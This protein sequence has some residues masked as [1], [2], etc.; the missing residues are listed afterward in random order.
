MFFDVHAHIQDALFGTVDW[1]LYSQKYG[2]SKILCNGTGEDDWA[3]VIHLSDQFSSVHPML[4]VHPWLVHEQ[5]KDWADLLR[6]YLQHSNAGLGEIGLDK[7]VRNVDFELQKEFFVKQLDIAHELQL[8]VTIHCLKAFGHLINLLNSRQRPPKG[9]LLHSYS[10]PL[11]LIDEFI[12]LG[13]YFSFSAYFLNDRKINQR[14]LFKEI[15]I[16]RIL[17]ESDA[18]HMAGPQKWMQ[19]QSENHSFL[20]AQNLS[21]TEP[22]IVL[23]VYESLAQIHSV[24]LEQLKKNISTNFHQL[25]G[26]NVKMDF[27]NKNRI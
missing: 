2:L 21:Q 4:G 19:L 22:A 25:F 16:N 9:F 12:E 17:I 18:P 20:L 8:P 7:W 11:E 24:P 27:P 5:S 15:P 14:Q 26:G 1:D 23:P 10:G 13:A 3:K 6:D